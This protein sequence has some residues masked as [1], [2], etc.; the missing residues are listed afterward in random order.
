MKKIFF[1]FSALAL[2]G[3]IVF[4]CKKA[5]PEKLVLDAPVISA[6]MVGETVS[7]SW[8]PITNATGYKVEFKK[9]SDAEFMVAGSPTYSPFVVTDF[10]FGNV[11]DREKNRFRKYLH[12]AGRQGGF[13]AAGGQTISEVSAGVV[14]GTGLKL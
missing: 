10:D 14:P 13:R 1:A 12:R 5:E 7:V 8:S 3:V 2:M 6:A 9:A 11:Y 4:S